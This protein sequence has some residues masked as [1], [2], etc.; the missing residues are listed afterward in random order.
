MEGSSPFSQLS[1]LKEMRKQ[2]G[3]VPQTGFHIRQEGFD[4]W[5]CTRATSAPP[6][7]PQG[8]SGYQNVPLPR[9][10]KL[11]P[12]GEVNS[13]PSKPGLLSRTFS[14]GLAPN[15][16]HDAIKVR[17]LPCFFFPKASVTSREGGGGG[18]IQ[19]TARVGIGDEIP[20]FVHP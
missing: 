11:A 12:V 2:G 13:S 8:P 15:S 16:N 17:L 1:R 3:S 19:S 7:G 14:S 18:L 6:R 20:D 5:G 9:F 4:I 10:S